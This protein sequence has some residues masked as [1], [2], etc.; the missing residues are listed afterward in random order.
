MS[1]SSPARDTHFPQLCFLQQ[2]SG[3][4]LLVRTFAI[5]HLVFV[6]VSVSFFYHHHHYHHRQSAE[7]MGVPP[8]DDD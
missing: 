7:L 4:G 6:V 1:I 5:I 2:S 8:P 3:S